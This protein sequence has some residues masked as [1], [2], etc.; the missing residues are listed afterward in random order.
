[1]W[2]SKAFFTVQ[3]AIQELGKCLSSHYSFSFLFPLGSL[4]HFFPPSVRVLE[5]TGKVH[6]DSE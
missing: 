1:M 4:T 6:W 2:I 5:G 3:K